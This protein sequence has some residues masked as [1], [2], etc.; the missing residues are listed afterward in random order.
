M[1]GIPGDTLRKQMLTLSK[2]SNRKHRDGINR[3]SRAPQEGAGVMD[4]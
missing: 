4:A 3:R 1:L 2:E